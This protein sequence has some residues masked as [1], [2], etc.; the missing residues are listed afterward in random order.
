M[1]AFP[2]LLSFMAILLFVAIK[3]STHGSAEITEGSHGK[4]VIGAI[5]DSSS[6]IGKEQKVALQ[7]AVEDFYEVSNQSLLLQIEDSHGEPVRAAI[8]FVKSHQVQV[9]LGPQTWEEALLVANIGNKNHIPILSFADA[10]PNWAI[11]QW[12]F[13]V[14]ATP[15]QHLQMN[16]VA[17]IVQSWEWHQVT[18]IY[19]DTDSS[20]NGV[21]PHLTDALTEA[22]VKIIH[23]LS[24]APLTSTTSLSEQLERLQR[25]QCRVFVVHLSFSSA[26][27]LFKKVKKMKMMEKSYVWI[28]TNPMTSLVH[29]I[30]ASSFSSMQG[31]IGVKSYFPENEPR[32]KDF[33]L[34]FCKRFGLKHPEEK[35]HEPGIFAVQAYDAIWTVC[36]A[37][38]E[39][40]ELGQELLQTI[41]LSDFQGLSGRIHFGHDQKLAPGQ[42]FQIINMMGKSYR[43]LGFWSSKL[44]FSETITNN[45]TYKSSMEHLGQV[46]WPGGPMYNPRGWT[47][48][49]TA[50]PLRI[51]VP[52]RSLF[53]S[54]VNVVYHDLLGNNI[55]FGGFAIDLF[56]ATV[57]QLPFYLPYD[58]FPFDGTYDALVEQVYLKKFDAVVGDVA[59]VANRYK[60][61]EFTH[62]YT[63]SGLVMIVPVQSK[64]CNKASLFLKPFTKAMWVLIGAINVYNGIVVWLIE[65]HHWPMLKG[66]ALN[67]MLTLLC[68]SFTTLFSLKGEKLHSSLSRMAMVAWL[69]VA[70][71]IMQTYTANLTS[72][73][74]V[75]QLEPTVDDI[76]TLQN[77]NA[78]VGYSSASFVGK[79]LVEVLRFNPKNI[80]TYTSPDEYARDLE[81]REIEAVFLEVP[82]AKL[83]L[84]RYCKGF[85]IAGPV[86]KVG[87]FGF[88]FQKGSPLLPSIIEAL[89]KVL[90]SGKLREL[91]N[92]MIASQECREVE[93][94]DE[95]PSLSPNSFLVLFILTGGTST[96][97]L[98]IY[99]FHLDNSMHEHRTIWRVMLAIIRHWSHGTKWFFRRVINGGTS[100]TMHYSSTQV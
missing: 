85:T 49:N 22:G 69:F 65:R 11:E 27:R 47:T 67:Q 88:A 46:I 86:Y 21:M 71:V 28:T 35:N 58:F 80:K 96:I 55:S 81:N 4:R 78:I 50:N 14:Q 13:L 18:V 54:Y 25:E 30:N 87:G 79:Y 3:T 70:L 8:D 17:A 98:V 77:S 63:E 23:H 66:S 5:I 41:L 36:L 89:L 52:T 34:K 57:K 53:E 16:A 44:G 93:S 60:H 12:P 75:Q 26:M 29:S 2:P 19:E 38:I 68:L 24:L 83:F 82:V 94:D 62:P 39:R 92:N 10:T 45:S 90:E 72:I 91:E 61:A 73:L 6:R 43:E 97:V 48:S 42:V 37:M 20:T 56:E 99:I 33:Y 74:T 7:M 32:F 31:I 1:N 9:I 51:G 100:N 84:A 59:I 15:N 76:E 95:I 64:T 40:N